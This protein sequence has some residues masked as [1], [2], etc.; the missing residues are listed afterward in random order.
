MN[1]AKLRHQVDV[2]SFAVDDIKLFLDTHPCDQDALRSYH[3]FVDMRKT[4]IENYEKECGPLLVDN[5]KSCDYWQWIN[6]PW[7]WEGDC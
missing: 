7:P 5:V 3:T 4:A 6:E 2:A 1:R